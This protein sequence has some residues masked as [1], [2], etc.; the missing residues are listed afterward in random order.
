VPAEGASHR[1]RNAAGGE[2]ERGPSELGHGQAGAVHG[3]ELR[4]LP[5][6]RF[7]AG[8]DVGEGHLRLGGQLLEHAPRRRLVREEH[9]LHRPSLRRLEG[10][11][12]LLICRGDVGV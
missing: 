2:G 5:A 1:C 10:A 3:A 4:R 7:G 8:G 9:L 11:A 6:G 12:A